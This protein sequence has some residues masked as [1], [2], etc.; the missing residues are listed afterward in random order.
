MYSKFQLYRNDSN[1]VQIELGA[2]HVHTRENF[3]TAICV[4]LEYVLSKTFY[5]FK[6]TL[7]NTCKLVMSANRLSKLFV[8]VTFNRNFL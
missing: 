4:L 5:A 8:P 1:V 2:K 7:F 6:K 3:D